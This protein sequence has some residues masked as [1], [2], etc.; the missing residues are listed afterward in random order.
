MKSCKNYKSTKHKQSGRERRGEYII[1]H[2]N[3]YFY[4]HLYATRTV[5]PKQN[6][7]VIYI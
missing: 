1:K 3:A 6:N 4:V 2:K 5:I 7:G